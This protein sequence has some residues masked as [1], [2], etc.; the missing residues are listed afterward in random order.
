MRQNLRFRLAVLAIAL[1]VPYSAQASH[2]ILDALARACVNWRAHHPEAHRD[3]FGIFRSRPSVDLTGVDIRKVNPA[4]LETHWTPER[5]TKV[6]ELTEKGSQNIDSLYYVTSGAGLWSRGGNMVKAIV[7]FNIAKVLS[8]EDFAD[9]NRHAKVIAAKTS[10]ATME[11]AGVSPND[12]ESAVQAMERVKLEAKAKLDALITKAGEHPDALNAIDLKLATVAMESAAGKT[13]V[14]F[15]IITSEQTHTK[16]AEYLVWLRRNYQHKK[17]HADPAVNKKVIE[18]L[19]RYF[20]LDMEKKET[21]LV[22]IEAG[23]HGLHPETGDPVTQTATSGPGVGAALDDMARSPRTVALKKDGKLYR[24]FDNIEVISN[25][26]LLHGTHVQALGSNPNLQITVVMVPKQPGDAG[27]EPYFVNGK[28]Q[29]IEKSALPDDKKGLADESPLFN[30]NTGEGPIDATAGDAYGFEHKVEL[31][32]KIV[33]P[34]KNAWDTTFTLDSQGVVGR[35]GIDYTALKEW[36]DYE[37][38]GAAPVDAAR[39]RWAT[40][41]GRP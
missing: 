19:D 41:A 18:A 30:T 40:L 27:G 3:M 9:V 26:A 34:K 21:H 33:R 14:P 6:A 37:R 5:A 23:Y 35:Y 32:H 10:E 13:Y 17:F 15:D 31:G 20:A 8:A 2:H 39:A 25:I 24:V 12:G 22:P 7:P 11:A 36:P 4:D 1:L 29:L 16:I 28:F 38:N